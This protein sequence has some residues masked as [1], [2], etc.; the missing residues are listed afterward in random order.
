MR[1]LYFEWDEEKNAINQDKHGVS[2]DEARLALFDPCRIIAEDV[3]HSQTEKRY[4]CFGKIDSN[5]MTVRFTYR[6]QTIRIIGAGYWRKGEK[7][8]EREQIQI[9]QRANRQNKN[10]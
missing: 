7:I 8:Y 5:I 10:R 1:K 4:Y 3:E 2:F 6:N 9:Q